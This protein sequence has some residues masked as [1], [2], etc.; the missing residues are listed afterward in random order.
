MLI[1]IGLDQARIDREAFA[2]HK[3]GRNARLD[4]PFEYTT[5]YFSLAEAFIAGT[6]KCRMIR[7]SIFDAQLA[8][9][10]I[11]E[12]NL[13]FTTDQPLRADRKGVSHDQHPDHQ[14]RIDRRPDPS[15]NNEVQVRRE[16]SG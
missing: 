2:T 9:P 3:A 12:V 5:E 1:G 16:T 13:H 14:F 8:E 10:A 4:D 11:G 15:T 6:R 7:D